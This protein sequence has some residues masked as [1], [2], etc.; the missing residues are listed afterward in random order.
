M[1]EVVVDVTEGGACRGGGQFVGCQ[2]DQQVIDPGRDGARLVEQA[3]VVGEQLLHVAGPSGRLL[4]LA[5]KLAPKEVDHGIEQGLL[6]G[7]QLLVVALGTEDN[8]LTGN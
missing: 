5:D 7:E 8:Q 3:A 4:R 2:L 6:F 1:G